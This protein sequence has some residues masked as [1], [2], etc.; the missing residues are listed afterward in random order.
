MRFYHD[1]KRVG[2]AGTGSLR[3]GQ[4]GAHKRRAER[5]G[6][7]GRAQPIRCS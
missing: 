4:N 3:A 1:V 5:V 2:T 7:P 6:R